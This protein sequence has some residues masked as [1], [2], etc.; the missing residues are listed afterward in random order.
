MA[1]ILVVDDDSRLN[2]LIC[3]HL[4]EG[5]HETI[6]CHC[7][8]DAYV[9]MY[10]HRFDAIISDIVMPEIDGFAFVETVRRIDQE[11]PILLISMRDDFAAKQQGFQ[12]GIDDYMVKPLNLNELSLR[13]D[14]LL[15]RTKRT[16]EN[17][18]SL[19]NFFMDADEMTVI[20]NGEPL[21]LT[22]REFRI[23]FKL[24]SRP[25][26]IFSRSQLMEE[27]WIENTDATLRAIDVYIT[28]LRDKLSTC[29]DFKLVTVR[30][31]GYKAVLL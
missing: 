5:G 21:A 8:Q 29:S 10:R 25:R 24:L 14:A 20:L 9:K 6:G 30:G 22:I 2:K 18:I 16:R 17:T 13:I 27:F 19:E 23:L 1:K 31:I 3:T 15:R 4:N 11:I 12:L 26:H 28:R 7:V